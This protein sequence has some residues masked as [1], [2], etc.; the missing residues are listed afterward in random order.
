MT[1]CFGRAAQQWR[2]PMQR[3]RLVAELGLKNVSDSPVGRVDGFPRG[4]SGGERKRCNIAVEM[5]RDPSA[6]FLDEP[7]S[8]LD[9]FQ[10]QNVMGALRDLAHNGRTVVCTIHQPRSSIFAM[11]DQLMLLTD[12]RL[13]YI[14]DAHAAVGY[15]ETLHFRCPT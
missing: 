12:G 15:F 7:T 1:G 13:V 4:L 6:I 9:S 11:F 10:A 14:G 3:R 8:G 2:L 5:V